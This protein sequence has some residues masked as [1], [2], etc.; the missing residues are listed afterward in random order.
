MSARSALAIT[1]DTVVRLFAPFLPFAAEE[2]WSWYRP[3]SVHNAQWPSPLDLQN[4]D[5]NPHIL[6]ATSQALVKLR[7][8]KSENKVSP[9]TPFLH[10]TLEVPAGMVDLLELTRDDLSLVTHIE[11]QFIIRPSAEDEVEV[12]DYELGEPPARK[13]RN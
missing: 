4:V 1:V 13:P 5:G 11:G 7:R 2:V 6:E 12:V 3:G 9:R 8:V 10:A